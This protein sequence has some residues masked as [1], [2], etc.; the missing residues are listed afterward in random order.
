MTGTVNLETHDAVFEDPII[1]I[2][3]LESTKTSLLLPNVVR[4]LVYKQGHSYELLN[5]DLAYIHE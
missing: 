2:T 5:A 3:R 4:P 1:I